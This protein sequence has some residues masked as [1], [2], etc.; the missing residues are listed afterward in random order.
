MEWKGEAKEQENKRE[1]EDIQ[2]YA[3]N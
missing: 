1:T 2:Q 3:N